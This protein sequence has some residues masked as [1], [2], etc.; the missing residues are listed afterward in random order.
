MDWQ[1]RIVATPDTLFGK[2]RVAGTRIGVEFVFDL[3]ASGWTQAQILDNYPQLAAA[4]LRALFA[5]A[6]D[7]VRD[8]LRALPE[9]DRI[10]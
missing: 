4:D 10:R 6:R 2:P 3:L 1:E 5:F 7:C 9:P 8:R